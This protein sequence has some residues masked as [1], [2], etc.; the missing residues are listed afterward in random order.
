MVMKIESQRGTINKIDYMILSYTH[1]D[2]LFTVKKIEKENKK[3]ST[4]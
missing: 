2:T 4:R 3:V 1:I